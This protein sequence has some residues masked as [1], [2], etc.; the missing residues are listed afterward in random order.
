M[1]IKMWHLMAI[2]VFVTSCVYF[3]E[4]FSLKLFDGI[5]DFFG[6][7]LLF[8]TNNIS[9]GYK[10]RLLV[11][12]LESFVTVVLIPF[13][14]FFGVF[15]CQMVNYKIPRWIRLFGLIFSILLSW[16]AFPVL[17]FLKNSITSGPI[18]FFFLAPVIFMGV[19]VLFGMLRTEVRG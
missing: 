12:I 13:I 18:G 11:Y 6:E 2:N 7:L 9:S 5:L 15:E 4:G 16:L 10:L 1:N 8:N 17:F 14:F 3:V 19:Q